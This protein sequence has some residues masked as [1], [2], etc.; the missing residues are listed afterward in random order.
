MVIIM[1]ARMMREPPINRA[2]SPEVNGLEN[3]NQAGFF[4]CNYK[5]FD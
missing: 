3:F 4:H 5:M 2:E 1:L